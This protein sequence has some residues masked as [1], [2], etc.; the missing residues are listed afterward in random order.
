MV[1]DFKAE[2]VLYYFGFR[3]DWNDVVQ[4]KAPGTKALL[5]DEHSINLSCILK[6]RRERDERQG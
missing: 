1:P 5:E 6:K 4:I 2:V 3:I